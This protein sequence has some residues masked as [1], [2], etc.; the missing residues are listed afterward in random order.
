[1][2][3]PVTAPRA[4]AALLLL[5]LLA[6]A[7]AHAD[8]G[9]WQA[10][11]AGGFEAWFPEQSGGH[12][13]ALFDLQGGDVAGGRFRLHYNTDTLHLALERMELGTPKVQLTAWLRGQ[14]IFAGLL[15]DYYQNGQSRPELAFYASYVQAGTEWKW[16]PADHHS[17]ALELSLRRWFFRE[18]SDTAETL[19]LPPEAWVFEP[20][21][22]Y[23]FWKI[24]APAEEWEPHRF[25][26]R[27][28]GVAFGLRL[29]LDVRSDSRAWGRASSTRNDPGDVIFSAHQWLRAG[30]EAHPLVRL[31]LEQHASWGEGQDDLTRHRAGGMNPYVIAIP[32]LPWAAILSERLFAAQL[33]VHVKIA[34][35]SRHE[36][37]A[38]FAAGAFN[39]LDRS[40]AL[41]TFDFA[42]GAGAFADLRFG[43]WQIHL[44]FAGAIPLDWLSGDPWL[45]ALLTL[46]ARL[47]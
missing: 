44:R 19:A 37:G 31:Q 43:R 47:R 13:W 25:F 23:T 18:T 20:R 8:E 34:P 11:L 46:G 5:G 3:R 45:S 24:R 1:M 38:L 7:V 40:G 42:A 33:S 36:L 28:Q 4:A 29:G 2:L 6:P 39:D 9:D 32:G 16:L 10:T 41:D 22:A 21:L 14:A 35:D 12:G 17:L 30:V 15:M 27:V 26:P